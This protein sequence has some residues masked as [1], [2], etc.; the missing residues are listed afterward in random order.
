MLK[1]LKR[2]AGIL[3]ALL[4]LVLAGCQ[5]KITDEARALLATTALSAKERAVAFAAIAPQLQAKAPGDQNAIQRA[6]GAHAE[7]LA[8]QAKALADLRDA[9]AYGSFNNQTVRQI[10]NMAETAKSRAE[11]FKAFATLVDWKWPV[12]VE[13]HQAALD[14]QAQQLA[15]LYEKIKPPEKK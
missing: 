8:A 7:G 9:V 12:F 14:L 10:G 1:S 4:V 11:S 13:T 3:P 6:A 2:S 15:A 5:A